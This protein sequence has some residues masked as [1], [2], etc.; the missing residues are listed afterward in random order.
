MPSLSTL[1]NPTQ[2]IEIDRKRVGIHVDDRPGRLSFGLA[3]LELTGLPLP[4][5]LQV[6]V[7][8]RRGKSQE[9]FHLG[10]TEG[11][12]RAPKD[13]SGL[14][15]DGVLLF[16]LLLVRQ[17]DPKLIASAESLRAESD[18]SAEGFVGLEIA[19]DL[20]EIPWE[21]VVLEQSGRA[22]V[23]I[24]RR[25]YP[26][27]GEAV[28]DPGFCALVLPE[29]VRRLAQHVA[30]D[31]DVL[32]QQEWFAFKSWLDSMK[33]GEPPCEDERERWI[34]RILREFCM[35]WAFATQLGRMRQREAAE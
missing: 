8:A 22:I 19:D 15:H 3:R 10:S 23:R 1:T 25:A 9:R 29:A 34:G 30:D 33:L 16:R 21:V 2:L 32:A 24:S 18:D 31:P 20:E 4:R 14:G 11:W 6:V 12:D 35:R 27:A 7:I 5:P 28:A 13:I 26:S 17:G